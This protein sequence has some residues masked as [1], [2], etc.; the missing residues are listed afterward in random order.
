MKAQYVALRARGA[1]IAMVCQPEATFDLSTAAQVTNPRDEDIKKL[2][3]RLTWQ[4]ENES[5]G[6]VSS[7]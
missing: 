2:N 6:L 3:K 4:T 7:P 1:Y 5:R